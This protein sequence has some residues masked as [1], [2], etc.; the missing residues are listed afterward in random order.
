MSSIPEAQAQVGG[1]T[2]TMSVRG[3]FLDD[4]ADR[5]CAFRRTGV[6]LDARGVEESVV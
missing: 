2:Q 6:E 3:H 5:P 1:T 4:R